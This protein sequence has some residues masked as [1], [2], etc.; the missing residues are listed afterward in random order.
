MSSSF[1]RRLPNPPAEQ[2]EKYML[3]LKLYILLSGLFIFKDTVLTLR[4]HLKNNVK[5]N[6][7][8]HFKTQLVLS[9]HQ[10]AGRR[11]SWACGGGVVSGHSYLLHF[12]N[13]GKRW[14]L[15][16]LG[17]CLISSC[18]HVINHLVDNKRLFPGAA[19]ISMCSQEVYVRAVLPADRP[20]RS[21]LCAPWL[22]ADGKED[23]GLIASASDFA[24]NL[25]PWGTISVFLLRKIRETILVSLQFQMQILSNHFANN[26]HCHCVSVAAFYLQTAEALSLTSGWDIARAPTSKVLTEMYVVQTWSISSATFRG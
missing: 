22:K 9:I 23:L 16:H 18:E 4:R 7:I 20:Q 14:W 6:S 1:C 15:L 12:W 3:T 11:S 5:I 10:E 8:W 21:I 19:M 24:T 13:N 17:V 2:R 25:L 26:H